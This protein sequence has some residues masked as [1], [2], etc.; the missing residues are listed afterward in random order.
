MVFLMVMIIPPGWLS[1]LIQTSGHNIVPGDVV[2]GFFK[3]QV[4][5][6]PYQLGQRANPFQAMRISK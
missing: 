2:D 5:V 1:R 6:L 4:N 3:Y